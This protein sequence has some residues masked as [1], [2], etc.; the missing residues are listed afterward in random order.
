MSFEGY[1]EHLCTKGHYT[2][3]DCYVGPDERCMVCNGSLVAMNLVDQTNGDVG[4]E[5]DL[6]MVEPA[7]TCPTC[8]QPIGH[9]RYHLNPKRKP[10]V[11]PE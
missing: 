9:A 2:T 11:E 8:H 5:W 6:E 3:S 7:P 1:Y 10:E 4:G